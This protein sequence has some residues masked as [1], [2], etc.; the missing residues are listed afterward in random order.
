MAAV[1]DSHPGA[2]GPQQGSTQPAFHHLG[3]VHVILF[4]GDVPCAGVATSADVSS[5]Y[6]SGRCDYGRFLSFASI[7]L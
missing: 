3:M 7:I 2:A 4:L 5:F 6:I 1:E